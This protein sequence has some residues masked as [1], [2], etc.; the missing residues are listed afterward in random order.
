VRPLQAAIAADLQTLAAAARALGAERA[1]E[2]HAE[3]QRAQ[4]RLGFM[5]LLAL[6]VGGAA[7]ALI[8]RGIVRPL[9]SAVEA[10]E[11]VADG[12]LRQL[13][14]AARNDEA[15]RVLAALGGM[16]GRL[17]LLVRAIRDSAAAV[18]RASD[19]ISQGNTELAA[20]TE[21]QAAA[22][23]ETAASVEELTAIVKQNSESAARARELAR[24]AS[25]LAEAS[26]ADVGGVVRTM[27]GIHQSSRK[28]SDI[29]GVIDGIAFQTNL[30]A[31]NAAVEAARAG[32]QGRGF[33]VVAAQ[34][35][36]LA[37]R[38]AAASRDIKKLV[39][40]ALGEAGQGSAAA[41]RAGGSMAKVVK[42]A[43]E[44]AQ[45]VADIAR[46][47]EEQRAGIE[48]VNTTI[49]QMDSSTQSNAALVQEI[50]GFIDALLAQAREL[51][52]A[53]SRFRL[54]ESVQERSDSALYRPLPAPAV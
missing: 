50:N 25:A 41:E 8:T 40:E 5:L 2:A 16:Q 17:N 14:L 18:S 13:A 34:V 32:D 22:L 42:V 4:W 19:R 43:H 35:R 33:G 3:S 26:G 46:A 27:Q 53:T 7:T 30:L 38:S 47:G 51:Q 28:V 39:G 9:R 20:R 45:L 6:A 49:S 15:G 29:V 37:Q 48:Q 11:K 23:E 36:E 44:L 1:Q 10:T 54:E 52:E 12:D 31:L 24:E 21:Q